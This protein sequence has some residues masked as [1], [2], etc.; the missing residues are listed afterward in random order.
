MQGCKVYKRGPS[1]EGGL[2]FFDSKQRFGKE[3]QKNT[4]KVLQV[5]NNVC[6]FA[7]AIKGL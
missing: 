1:D 6:I 2:L 7:P 5:S 4:A 3:K